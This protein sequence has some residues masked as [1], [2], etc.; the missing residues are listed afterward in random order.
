[1]KLLEAM[2]NVTEDLG[3]VLE[4]TTKTSLVNLEVYKEDVLMVEVL[5]ERYEDGY[6]TEETLKELLDV[7]VSE[8][9]LKIPKKDIAYTYMHY[10]D[11]RK[12]I[13]SLL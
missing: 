12:A 8:L 10:L 11:F 9:S 4:E 2:A 3:V 13:A 1:M 5:I 7:E 6:A